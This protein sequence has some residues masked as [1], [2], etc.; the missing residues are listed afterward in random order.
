MEQNKNLNQQEPPHTNSLL[1]HDLRNALSPILMYTEIL[2]T[3][4]TKLS[5]DS[6][7][8]V[9]RLIADAVKEMNTMIQSRLEN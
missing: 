1:A 6:E 7:I 3:S 8:E 4:L 9:T 2:E 5:L